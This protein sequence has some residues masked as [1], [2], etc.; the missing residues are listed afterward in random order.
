LAAYVN[1]AGNFR[2]TTVDQE[3]DQ[4]KWYGATLNSYKTYYRDVTTGSN[5]HAATKGWDECTGLGTPIK[6]SGF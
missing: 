2:N 6:P 1:N 4:Y 3:N 5:G